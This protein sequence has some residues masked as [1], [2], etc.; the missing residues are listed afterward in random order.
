[1][2]GPV[3]ALVAH[4]LPEVAALAVSA[5]AAMAMRIQTGDPSDGT[6]LRHDAHEGQVGGAEVR[7]KAAP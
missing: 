4:E 6:T 7:R 1:L 5:N 2:F 3:R